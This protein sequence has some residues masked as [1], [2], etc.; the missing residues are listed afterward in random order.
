MKRREQS[1]TKVSRLQVN[2]RTRAH[3]EGAPCLGFI[4]EPEA[5]NLTAHS[6]YL[7]AVPHLSA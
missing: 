6:V 5:L 2:P 4:W 3:R 7:G 1:R